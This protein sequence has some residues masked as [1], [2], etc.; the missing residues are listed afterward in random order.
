M[1]F[2][3][4]VAHFGM[5]SSLGADADQAHGAGRAGLLPGQRAVGPEPR[6]SRQPPAGGLGDARSAARRGADRAGRRPRPGDARPRAGEEQGR[7]PR[8]ALR[9]PRGARLPPDPTDP[10]RDG[11][12]PA[13]RRARRL[14][15]ARLRVRAGGGRR[16][17]RPDDHPSP[18]RPRAAS[19][20]SRSA[21]STGPTPGSS[22]PGSWPAAT[23]TCSPASGRHRRRP[24]TP[25]ACDWPTSSPA[26]RWR[27]STA[28]PPRDDTDRHA[29]PVHR[30]R[31]AAPGARPSRARRARAA[32]PAGGRAGGLDLLPHARLLPP[33]PA[34]HHRL[35]QRLR[36]V[37]GRPRARPGAGRAAGRHQPVRDGQPG[38]AARGADVGRPRSPAPAVHDPPRRVRRRLPLPAVAHRRGAAGAGRHHAAGVPGRA[39]RGGRQRDLLPHGGGAGAAGPALGRL[40]RVDPHLAAACRPWPSASS[41]STPT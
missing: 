21:P 39:G 13:A 4:R 10:V 20:R 11:R 41:A 25:P 32:R 12:L 36:G 7:R 15:R 19:T 17:R 9:D 6:R 3:A 2:Q 26:S 31:G 1:V 40:R 35:R 30:L 5:L 34:R 33:P 23:R 22:C 24:G 27:S 18:A 28:R 16:C 14:R 29:L 38:G 37:G 8:E